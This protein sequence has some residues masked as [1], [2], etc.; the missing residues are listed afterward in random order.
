MKESNLYKNNFFELA[1]QQNAVKNTRKDQPR[2]NF[3]SE[4]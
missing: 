4:N 2:K 1:S 3:N